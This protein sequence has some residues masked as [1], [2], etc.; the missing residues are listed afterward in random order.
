MKATQQISI[1]NLHRMNGT[2]TLNAGLCCC[3]RMCNPAFLFLTVF[4]CHK[5]KFMRFNSG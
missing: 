2:G 3:L 5:L 4:F 1:F